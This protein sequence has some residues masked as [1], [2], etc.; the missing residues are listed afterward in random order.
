LPLSSQ[1]RA[2]WR[3]AALLVLLCVALALVTASKPL[4]GALLEVLASGRA[5]II[6]YPLQGAL[7]FVLLA[8][9]SAMFAFVSI[10]ILVP[11]A[12]FAW[13]EPLSMLMLWLGW[14]LGG[15]VAYGIARYLGRPVVQWLMT[16]SV[17]Q[18]LERRIHP[19][20]RLGLIV[21][22]QLGLPS[23]I[24]GYL[25]GLVRYPPGKFLVALAAGELPYAVATIWLGA[26]FVGARSGMVIAVGLAIAALSVG[27]F[28]LLR[29]RL[30][31]YGDS[32]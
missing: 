12:V 23:E 17:L 28:H 3:Q 26:G 16:D 24:P 4:H 19:D 5:V 15:I 13:G 9:V 20:T 2:V 14:I 6:D 30:R 21:L 32:N 27:A 31:A 7:L 8:A 29:G 18:R 25:L 1:H 22:L 10:A 11:V